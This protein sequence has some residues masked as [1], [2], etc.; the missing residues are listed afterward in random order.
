MHA[1]GSSSRATAAPGAVQWGSG[2]TIGE[3]RVSLVSLAHWKLCSTSPS[4]PWVPWASVPHLPR[5]YATLRLP[6]VPLGVLHLSLVPRYLACFSP[7]V[8]S[9]KG[10]WPGRSAQTT[11]GPLVTRSPTPGSTSR[12]QVALPSSRVPPVKTCPALRPRWCPA[13][14]PFRTQ[15]CCLPALAHRRL[16]TTI[17]I[18]GLNHAAYL[19]ASPGFVRPLTGRHAGSLLTCWLDSSQMGLEHQFSP[20]GKQQPI[21]WSD[22]QFQG[23]GLTLA[24]AGGC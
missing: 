11:P 18:S 13:H 10:S 4:L 24:R 19:L 12:S 6:P 7:F 3:H 22:L 21:S 15:D 2:D 20:T 5:Y 1:S 14:S 9:P 17:H 8:V 16:T 23:F